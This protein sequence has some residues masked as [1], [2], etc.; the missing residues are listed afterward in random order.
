MA[1]PVNYASRMRCL[2]QRELPYLE[3]L[4]LDLYTLLALT[5]GTETT[6]KDVHDAWSVWRTHTRPDHQSLIPFG[7][8]TPAVQELDRKYMQAIHDAVNEYRAG[9]VRDQGRGRV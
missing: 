2:V 4:L 5:R 8:L 3:P 6:L 7:E 1:E 9:L